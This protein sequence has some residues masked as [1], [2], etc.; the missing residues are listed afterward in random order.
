MRAFVIVAWFGG[1]L[2]LIAVGILAVDTR[3]WFG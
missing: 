3:R 2:V 1:L